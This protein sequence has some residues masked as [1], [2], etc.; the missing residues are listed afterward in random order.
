MKYTEFFEKYQDTTLPG[1][2]HFFTVE[3]MYQHFKARLVHEVSVHVPAAGYVGE[4]TNK[5]AQEGS[6]NGKI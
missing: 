3:E 1:G 6:D 2:C 5:N 4:L